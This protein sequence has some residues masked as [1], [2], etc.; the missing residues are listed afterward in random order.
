MK[1]REKAE[2]AV[3]GEFVPLDFE[4]LLRVD[5]PSAR[6]PRIPFVPTIARYAIRTW[7]PRTMAFQNGHSPLH[8]K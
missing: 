3:A 1:A 5:T 8:P 4:V 6:S 2:L 7:E